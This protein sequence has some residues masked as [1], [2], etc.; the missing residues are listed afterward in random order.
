[1]SIMDS[2]HC[3]QTISIIYVI[4]KRRIREVTLRLGTCG[5]Q[6]C[7]R[8]CSWI[9][10]IVTRLSTVYMIFKSRM[11]EVALTLG[12]LW[13]TVLCYEEFRCAF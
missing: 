1:M 12:I 13:C 2:N 3:H 9:K 5:V 4:S 10:F 11:T 8:G 7:D 6:C